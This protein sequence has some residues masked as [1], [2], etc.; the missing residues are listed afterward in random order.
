MNILLR[1]LKNRFNNL[2]LSKKVKLKKQQ[3]ENLKSINSNS[4]IFKK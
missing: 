1:N 4:F 3:K 2:S